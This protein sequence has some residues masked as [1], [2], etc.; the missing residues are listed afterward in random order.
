MRNDHKNPKHYTQGDIECIDAMIAAKG[1][2]A[3]IAYCELCVFKYNWRSREKGQW[4]EDQDKINWYTDKAIE[5]F[6]RKGLEEYG[7]EEFNVDNEPTCP[8]FPKSGGD[9]WP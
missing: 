8:G 5:L 1:I 4:L 9:N 6:L 7:Y 3:V 2:D